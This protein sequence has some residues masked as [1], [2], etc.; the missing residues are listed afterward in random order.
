M[1]ARWGARAESAAECATRLVAFLTRL[2]ALHPGP[3]AWDGLAGEDETL[4][5]E[6][7]RLGPDVAQAERF[8]RQCRRDDGDPPEY[9]GFRLPL[10]SPDRSLSLS[11]HCG[12]GRNGPG[13]GNSVALFF[14]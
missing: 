3:A 10:L 1:L 2:A 14:P 12:A 11:I 5:P 8:A 13:T 9:V 4:P 7:W 6:G